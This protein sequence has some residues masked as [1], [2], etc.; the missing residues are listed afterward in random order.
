M[1]AWILTVG[2]ALI[3]SNQF[4]YVQ[5]M[6][7]I[8]QRL[9]SYERL[10]FTARVCTFGRADHGNGCVVLDVIMSERDRCAIR[11]RLDDQDVAGM[12]VDD[13]LVTEWDHAS[14]RWTSY[15]LAEHCPGFQSPRL[16][17]TV[18]TS[19]GK[20][21]LKFAFSRF[22][23]PWTD[24]PSPYQWVL[25]KL[26]EADVQEPKRADPDRTRIVVEASMAVPGVPAM[27]IL[28]F[29]FDEATDLPRLERIAARLS[30]PGARESGTEFVYENVRVN[31]ELPKEAFTFTP[32]AA[33][34]FVEAAEL[35]PATPPLVGKPLPVE[36]TD[37][38][39][40]TPLRFVAAGAAT[41]TVILLWATWCAP[42]KL[43][44]KHLAEIVARD[45]R[46]AP[47]ILT[48]SI[49][50]DVRKPKDYFKNA[51]F[52]F[53]NAHDPALLARIGASGVPTTIV[54]D[55]QGIVRAM[56]TGWGD[57]SSEAR[58]HAALREAR[59]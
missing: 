49:D 26:A 8:S 36:E 52:R 50:T 37:A 25:Q 19:A 48:V 28:R 21:S 22:M 54:L 46:D 5:L 14:N 58:L 10:S 15:P 34:R 4:S 53:E 27:Q 13:G 57:A 41:P 17:D 29:E 23:L 45:G 32:P 40:G 16:V 31:P 11:A 44:M 35:A 51:G 30:F 1:V 33:M 7:S 18:D 24:S 9:E 55:K 38:L 12:I 2:T 3:A 59:Q 39:D 6:H 42:C 47:R 20:L 56:W 43:E